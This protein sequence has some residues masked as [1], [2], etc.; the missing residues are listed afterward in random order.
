MA[1]AARAAPSRSTVIPAG[2]QSSREGRGRR[3]SANSKSFAKKE[4]RR[5]R[6][7]SWY[8]RRSDDLSAVLFFKRTERGP[9]PPLSA[10]AKAEVAGG[11]PIGALP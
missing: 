7:R 1:V 9:C 10:P 2:T 11:D 4:K 5:R 6:I 8:A 3:A